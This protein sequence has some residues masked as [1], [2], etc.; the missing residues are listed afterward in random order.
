MERSFSLIALGSQACEEMEKAHEQI[1]SGKIEEMWLVVSKRT[2]GA[3]KLRKGGNRICIKVQPFIINEGW[4]C[5][6]FCI[7]KKNVE[8]K[9]ET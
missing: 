4:M 9:I 2:C 7:N 5:Q 1:P 3:Q 8:E 6:I